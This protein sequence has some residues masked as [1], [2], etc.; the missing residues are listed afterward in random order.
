MLNPMQI[1]A[2]APRQDVRFGSKAD[3]CGA[4]GISALPPKADMCSATRDVRFVPKADMV[5]L[6]FDH[7]VRNGDYPWRQLNAE[8]PRRLKV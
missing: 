2:S 8:Q 5:W 6:L 3:M 4:N 7:L 1:L